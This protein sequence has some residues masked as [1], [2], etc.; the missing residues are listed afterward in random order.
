[1]TPLTIAMTKKTMKNMTTNNFLDNLLNSIQS[2]EQQTCTVYPSEC[3][4]NTYKQYCRSSDKK[5]LDD[6]KKVVEEFNLHENTKNSLEKIINNKN[7]LMKEALTITEDNQNAC[8]LNFVKYDD[9]LIAISPQKWDRL[10]NLLLRFS[11]HYSYDQKGDILENDSLKKSLNKFIR[12]HYKKDTTKLVNDLC[13]TQKDDILHLEKLQNV[14]ENKLTK[15]NI[16]SF[17]FDKNQ[18][19]LFHDILKNFINLENTIIAFKETNLGN[20]RLLHL[21]YLVERLYTKLYD[22]INKHVKDGQIRIP[23]TVLA[24]T[25][26]SLILDLCPSFLFENN[27]FDINKL[28]EKDIINLFDL[29]INSDFIKKK[30]KKA[31]NTNKGFLEKYS[32]SDETLKVVIQVLISKIYKYLTEESL[33]ILNKN[34]KEIT[35]EESQILRL[36]EKLFTE[37]PV[38]VLRNINTI[39][40]KLGY[41]LIN[42][43][44]NSAPHIWENASLINY[45]EAYP[46]KQPSKKKE[47]TKVLTIKI[48]QDI[49]SLINI[50]NINRPF[51]NSYNLTNEFADTK[52]N[53]HYVQRIF[54]T[55]HTDANT[56]LKTENTFS[57][58]SRL[59]IDK[60]SLYLLLENIIFELGLAKK[61]ENNSLEQFVSS[62]PLLLSF[63]NLDSSFILKCNENTNEEGKTLLK[64]IIFLIAIWDYDSIEQKTVH[65]ILF[66]NSQDQNSESLPYIK[67]IKI[68]RNLYNKIIGMRYSIITLFEESILYSNFEFF[69]VPLF[70][71]SRGRQYFNN[72]GLNIQGHHL[73]KCL[74][75]PYNHDNKITNDTMLYDINNILSNLIDD[76]LKD[77]IFKESLKEKYNVVNK[78]DAD[79]LQQ[80][81][82]HDLSS[83]ISFFHSFFNDSNYYEELKEKHF[84]S[85]TPYVDFEN[86]LSINVCILRDIVEK[87]KKPKKLA[88]AF[89]FFFSFIDRPYN[90]ENIEPIFELDATASGTQMTSFL[91]HSKSLAEICHI[92]PTTEPFID[93]YSKG[94]YDFKRVI[95]TIFNEILPPS[96]D[97]NLDFSEYNERYQVEVVIFINN[98]R[99]QFV[100]KNKDLETETETDTSNLHLHKKFILKILEI[101]NK[102]SKHSMNLIQDIHEYLITTNENFVQSIYK[103]LQDEDSYLSL[104][105]YIIG[106]MLKYKTIFKR[107]S[108]DRALNL[109]KR[110]KTNRFFI[111]FIKPFILEILDNDINY[112][113]EFTKNKELM[114]FVETYKKQ[115]NA[116][117]SKVCKDTKTLTLTQIF[118]LRLLYLKTTNYK[119]ILTNL[120]NRELPKNTSMTYG[121]NSTPYGRIQENIKIIDELNNWSCNSIVVKAYARLYEDF[122]M[123]IF[124]PKYLADAAIL[125]DISSIISSHV[126]KTNKPV[127]ITNKFI[128]HTLHPIQYRSLKVSTNSYKGMLRGPQLTTKIAKTNKSNT[129]FLIDYR[130]VK[131]TIGPNIIHSMDAFIVQ[132]VR[133]IVNDINKALKAKNIKY[134]FYITTNH[135]CFSSNNVNYLKAILELSYLILYEY[136]YVHTLDNNVFY[137]DVL[138]IIDKKI[139]NKLVISNKLLGDKFVK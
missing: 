13:K 60:T 80:F 19:S 39:E 86:R 14:S 31:K 105:N 128:K 104:L 41:L 42:L 9:Q 68:L 15:A 63:Y 82:Q 57:E 84:K 12:Y 109:L 26:G 48:K 34:K 124:R 65:T 130:K 95:N 137:Q 92:I 43:L 22:V 111:E 96:L 117:L 125:K 50:L 93:I 121:Y 30:N 46:S 36:K 20:K 38:D 56:S 44:R 47:K 66:P 70:L 132:L 133:N 37:I 64:K 3:K 45:N 138:N 67:N 110:N 71:D 4:D 6:F 112:D 83:R 61:F 100:D 21:D 53:Q 58:V 55:S 90:F 135:D 77:Q 127:I 2:Y 101:L 89:L 113:I 78:K 115:A 102:N 119:E 114:W 85:I 131:N 88:Q 106:E 51:F 73:T 123:N 76:T 120:E 134:F 81:N 24:Q 35:L 32:F 79:Q 94:V 49:A 116:L 33:S 40:I 136:N 59:C 18:I 8:T 108:F 91:L 139:K 69:Y 118:R 98:L 99:K 10:F 75:K 103:I 29:W 107:N 122:F 129:Q 7:Q 52:I 87:I 25:L 126:R 74:V 16:T 23:L 97:T 27:V 11:F 72:K 54:N 1:M 17:L 62:I 5:F 28:Y